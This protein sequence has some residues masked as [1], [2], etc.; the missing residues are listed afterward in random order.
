[1]RVGSQAEMTARALITAI[2]DL[3]MNNVTFLI[4]L[5][6]SADSNGKAQVILTSPDSNVRGAW[7]G[8]AGPTEIGFAV[9]RELGMPVY[10]QMETSKNE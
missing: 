4:E 7:D 5:K 3:Q 8:L 6:R 9:R 1:M 2:H 10:P